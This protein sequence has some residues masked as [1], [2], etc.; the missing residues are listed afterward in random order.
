ME[1][2]NRILSEFRPEENA[3][4]DHSGKRKMALEAFQKFSPLGWKELG[5]TAVLTLYK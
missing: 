5:E 3:N 4:N 2:Y 1:M